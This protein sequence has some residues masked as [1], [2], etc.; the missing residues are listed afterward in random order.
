MHARRT[1]RRFAAVAAALLLD[2]CSEPFAPGDL[3][4]TYVMRSSDVTYP[5]VPGLFG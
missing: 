4:G 3:A 1:V 5:G 2:S